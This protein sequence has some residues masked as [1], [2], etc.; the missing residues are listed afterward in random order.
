MKA[1]FPI[2]AAALLLAGCVQN[3]VTGTPQLSRDLVERSLVKGKTTKAD[4]RALLGEPQTVSAGSIAPGIPGMAAETWVYT[5][6]ERFDTMRKGAAYS[7]GH[8]AVTNSNYDRTEVSML[9]VTFDA[10]GRVLGHMFTASNAGA[11]R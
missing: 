7:F 10:R 2:A 9:I 8:Y 1:I 5:K 6:T 11:P 3:L 4:V